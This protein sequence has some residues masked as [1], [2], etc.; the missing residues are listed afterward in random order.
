MC[1][2]VQL[3]SS[4]PHSDQLLLLL[5]LFFNL[6]NLLGLFLNHMVSFFFNRCSHSFN[7][8]AQVSFALPVTQPEV[9]CLFVFVICSLCY[10]TCE[11]ELVL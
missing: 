7:E 3:T 11:C 9:F 10:L 2:I 8:C 6:D 5:F 1:L 4:V